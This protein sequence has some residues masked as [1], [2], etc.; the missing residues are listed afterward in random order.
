MV[1][2]YGRDPVALEFA[3]ADHICREWHARGEHDVDFRERMNIFHGPGWEVRP[4]HATFA[5]AVYPQAVG[6]TRL[7]ISPYWR[8]LSAPR[9]Q[10]GLKRFAE[11]VRRTVAPGYVWP[12]PS[13]P[14][15]P[16]ENLITE[17]RLPRLRPALITY[18]SWPQV[19]IEQSPSK[20]PQS[21][22]SGITDRSIAGKLVP[23]EHDRLA[24]R[25]PP[26][27]RRKPEGR[28]TGPSTKT[29]RLVTIATRRLPA[30]P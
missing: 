21:G 22:L 3:T 4:T 2:R 20:E 26:I 28:G 17:R 10:V 29:R 15:D 16:L 30:A 14:A 1:R 6:L 27:L 25:P 19:R 18:H 9:N 5:A 12:Q 13:R 8:S 7:L 24:A 23:G 11:E